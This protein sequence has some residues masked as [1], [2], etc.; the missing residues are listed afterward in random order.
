MATENNPGTAT[1]DTTK[2]APA[3]PDTAK[4]IGDPKPEQTPEKKTAPARN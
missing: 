1:Q 3:T 2:T 4:P